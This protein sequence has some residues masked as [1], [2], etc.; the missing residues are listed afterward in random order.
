MVHTCLRMKPSAAGSSL[1]ERMQDGVAKLKRCMGC[2]SVHYCS[3]ECQRAGWEGGH[4]KECKRLKS[5]KAAKQA[6]Q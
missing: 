2:A 3:E 5:A 1:H 4:R 6:Q